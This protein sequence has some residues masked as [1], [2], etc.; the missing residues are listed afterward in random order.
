MGSVAH[1]GQIGKVLVPR[2]IEMDLKEVPGEIL[3]GLEIVFVDHVDEVLP[4][5][6]LE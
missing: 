1:R 3:T 6:L 2:E 5:A 4:Q